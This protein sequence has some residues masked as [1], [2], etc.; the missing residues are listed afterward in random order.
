MDDK[1]I[2]RLQEY[3]KYDNELNTLRIKNFRSID[4]DM[5]VAISAQMYEQGDEVMVFSLSDLAF[6]CG[7]TQYNY[8]DF[9]VDLK[10]M[11]QKLLEAIGEVVVEDEEMQFNLFSTF[12][13]NKAKHTLRVRVNPD[14]MHLY[15]AIQGNF[16]MFELK[17]FISLNSK[18]SKQIY[19]LL[20]Q[21]RSTGMYR[22]GMNDFKELLG[23]S[24]KYRTRDI[25][26]KIL[27][28]S[29]AEL[30]E[31][32]NELKCEPIRARKR[33]KPIVGFYFSFTPQSRKCQIK[34]KVQEPNGKELDTN[35]ENT[36]VKHRTCHQ[37]TYDY[38]ELER[39]LLRR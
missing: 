22:V 37:R 10:M 18:Y 1:I 34:N 24:S 13:I 31:Y 36:R 4:W 23:I 39:E 26:S 38:E 27:A 8:D 15:N 25:I 5:F 35:S 11:N 17:E 3:V 19:R 6:C 9:M 20:K 2:T 21:F 7:Y 14:Y 29:V 12:S 32:F 16:T 28:P 33:G 30:S